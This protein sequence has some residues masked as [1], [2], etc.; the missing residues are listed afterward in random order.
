MP[1]VDLSKQNPLLLA[2]ALQVFLTACES[3]I[4]KVVHLAFFLQKS[5]LDNV[6]YL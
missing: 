4:I 5:E 6:E 2:L 3:M 1:L